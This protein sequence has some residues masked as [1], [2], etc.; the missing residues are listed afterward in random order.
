MISYFY[1]IIKIDELSTN[2]KKETL[3]NK[4]CNKADNSDVIISFV[5]IITLLVNIKQQTKTKILNKMC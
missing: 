5:D 1:I 3:R 4:N 2:K